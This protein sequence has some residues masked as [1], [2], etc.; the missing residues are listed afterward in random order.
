LVDTPKGGLNQAEEVY[1]MVER[2]KGRGSYSREFKEDA[3]RLV[4]DKG[5]PVSRV[6]RDLGLHENTI[7]KWMAQYRSDPEGASA[8]PGDKLAVELQALFFGDQEVEIAERAVLV[9]AGE[10]AL[11][12]AFAHCPGDHPAR[13]APINAT[14]E[15]V[16]PAGNCGGADAERVGVDAP[17]FS[18]AV[19]RFPAVYLARAALFHD[20]VSLRLR[21]AH[22]SP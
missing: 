3:V 9:L 22:M 5:V 17:F 6:A 4:A 12:L 2:K 18:A 21:R 19:F 8:G 1:V 7:Y 11:N 15:T 10:G 16:M 13:P 20:M 14:V